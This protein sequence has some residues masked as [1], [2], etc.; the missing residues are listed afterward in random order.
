[1][2]IS[3]AT[4]ADIPALCDLLTELFSQEAEFTP[5]PDTQRRGLSLILSS[6]E[7]GTILIARPEQHARALGMV[8]LLYTVSTALGERVALLE[9]MVVAGSAR[10]AGIGSMLLKEAI[11]TARAAGCAR[12]TLLTDATNEPARRFYLRHGFQP[13]P[14]IPL[15]LHPL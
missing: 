4:H 8:S 11:A 6:P 9:D 2:V 5:D 12:L 7:I 15:R 3:T 10:D 14:M 13:S 1:M